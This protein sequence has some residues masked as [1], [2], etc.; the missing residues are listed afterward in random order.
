MTH[1]E[2]VEADL[3]ALEAELDVARVRRDLDVFERVLATEFRTIS[4][5]GMVS[6]REQ[7]LADFRAG[8]LAVRSSRSTD[9]VI[10]SFGEMAVLNGRAHLQASMD[11]RDISGVFAYTHVYVF[12]DGRWQVVSAHSSAALP[13]WVTF[14]SLTLARWFGKA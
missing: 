11:G 4:P 7:M 3:H 10:R 14:L 9:L 6:D 12:R 1:P 5:N 2:N 13:R 8:G